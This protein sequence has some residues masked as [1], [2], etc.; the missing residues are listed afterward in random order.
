MSQVV[1][2]IGG[3][4][5]DREMLIHAAVEQL[6]RKFRLVKTSSLYET[7]AWGGKSSGDY[8]NQAVVVETDW[9]PEKVLDF[10]QAVEIDLGR[11]RK[12]KW[13]DRTMDIDI[14]YFGN[15]VIKTARL[16]VPH[17]HLDRK[18]VV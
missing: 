13:G 17:P 7:A 9:E 16:A 18:S 4:L 6:G 11:K 3:N 5:G 10:T 12:E 2:L 14:I 8:L 15:R 1:L